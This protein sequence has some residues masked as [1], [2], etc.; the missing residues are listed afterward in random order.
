MSV[1][2]ILKGKGE[3][4]A[5]SLQFY[6]PISLM[7]NKNQLSTKAFAAG[8]EEP[9]TLWRKRRN[10]PV[11]EVKRPQAA[12]LWLSTQNPSE[13]QMQVLGMALCKAKT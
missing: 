13:N 6:L 10:N 12:P 3:T 11:P 7:G 5:K 2:P 4:A 8:N 9:L 1:I